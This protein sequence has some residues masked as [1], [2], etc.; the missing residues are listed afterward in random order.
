MPGMTGNLE[1]VDHVTV[2]DN[3]VIGSGGATNAGGNTIQ[4][5]NGTPFTATLPDETPNKTAV[6]WVPINNIEDL[7]KFQLI[8]VQLAGD[9]ISLTVQGT[10]NLGLLQI[11]IYIASKKIL[12]FHDGI[13]QA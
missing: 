2:L 4:A 6:W 13:L 11:R 1:F 9:D 10:A 12:T 8:E 3:I 5:P 7:P